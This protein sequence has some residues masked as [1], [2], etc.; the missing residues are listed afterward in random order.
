MNSQMINRTDATSISVTDRA[1]SSVNTTAGIPYMFF[2][3]SDRNHQMLE[4]VII[5]TCDQQSLQEASAAAT[6][7]QN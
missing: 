5:V 3:S 4:S 2:R 7:R 6:K 1:A